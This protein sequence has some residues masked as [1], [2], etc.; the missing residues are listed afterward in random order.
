MLRPLKMEW[1]NPSHTRRLDTFHWCKQNHAE[2]AT[3][4]LK[5]TGNK[6]GKE[7]G[8][9]PVSLGFQKVLR[10]SVCTLYMGT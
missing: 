7:G 6:C 2:N 9:I 1:R 5:R 3:E 4:I 8:G 10:P